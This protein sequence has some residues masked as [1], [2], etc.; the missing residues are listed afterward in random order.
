MPVSLGQKYSVVAQQCQR[1][2]LFLNFTGFTIEWENAQNTNQ[3]AVVLITDI[4]LT[5][6]VCDVSAFNYC[7]H[8]AKLCLSKE[9]K[10][11]PIFFYFRKSNYLR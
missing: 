11:A 5:S 10:N 3:N 9:K 2:D 7:N 6:P 1:Y 8:N 4:E